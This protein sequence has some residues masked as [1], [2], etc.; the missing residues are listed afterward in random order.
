M[1]RSFT[2]AS[3]LAHGLGHGSATLGVEM[4]SPMRPAGVAGVSG[5]LL[6]LGVGDGSGINIDQVRLDAARLP[7]GVVSAAAW[8]ATRCWRRAVAA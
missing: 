7:H 5:D 6:I 8:P 1:R 4:A 3:A 2:N